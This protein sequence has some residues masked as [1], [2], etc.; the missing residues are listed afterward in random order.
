M[1]FTEFCKEIN[2]Y[3][4]DI[5]INLSE[6]Q[7]DKLYK[8]M[9]MLIEW[10]TK[11]NL[12]A[13]TEPKDIILKHFVDSFT[14]NRFIKKNSKL[15]DVGTGAGFP[16]IPLSIL[17]EDINITLVDSLNKRIMFLDEVISNLNLK[18]V[19]TVHARI[20]DFAHDANY[21]K[22]FDVATS[23][24]VASLSVLAEYMVALLRVNGKCICMKGSEI[25]E[26]LKNSQ[27][28]IDIMGGEVE[29]VES[30]F[31]PKTNMKRNIIV[32]NKVYTT[33]NMYPRK[34]AIIKK[35]PI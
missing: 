12:T 9:N 33:P 10:N 19:S 17:R 20:E 14:V 2:L 5:E 32:L 13:I 22:K 16:G 4:N 35:K 25:E 28:V 1:N 7:L 15:V 11:I 24:A 27:K 34:A 8:Y 26:E 23:R 29:K 6:S 31:L 3:C 30:F 18:N 21:R